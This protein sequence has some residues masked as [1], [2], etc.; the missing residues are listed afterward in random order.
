MDTRG[1][2]GREAR[3][4]DAG[5]GAPFTRPLLG[6]D[7]WAAGGKVTRRSEDTAGPGAVAGAAVCT[8]P[9]SAPFTLIVRESKGPSE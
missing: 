1:H 6:W 5:P 2:G 8:D 7:E 9:R 3:G 4:A